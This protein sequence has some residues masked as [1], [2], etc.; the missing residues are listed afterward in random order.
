MTGEVRSG[1]KDA[2][3]EAGAGRRA[4]PNL[5]AG[6]EPWMMYWYFKCIPNH[7]RFSFDVVLSLRNTI[8][9]CVHFISECFDLIQSYK[10]SCF[11]KGLATVNI[12]H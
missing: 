6:E 10:I 8:S 4:A 11:H 2:P 5:P 3:A 1:G 7:A 12:V 9:R